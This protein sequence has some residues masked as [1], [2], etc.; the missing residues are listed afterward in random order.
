M[1]PAR[2]QKWREVRGQQYRVAVLH[3]IGYFAP[4][5]YEEAREWYELAL[6]E[7]ESGDN[8]TLQPSI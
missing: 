4:P 1:V 5:D 3:R 7:A 8:R 6:S 2:P